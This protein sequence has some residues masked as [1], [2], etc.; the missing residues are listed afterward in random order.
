MHLNKKKVLLI[1]L[2]SFIIALL[3]FF[4][5]DENVYGCAVLYSGDS[6]TPYFVKLRNFQIKVVS[7]L[8]VITFVG[9]MLLN[10]LIISVKF[11]IEKYFNNTF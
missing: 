3:C 1:L 10:F 2:C 4:S 7:F 9:I 6:D 8:F 11:V 5:I